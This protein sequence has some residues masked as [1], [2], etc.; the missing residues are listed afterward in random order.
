LA[1]VTALDDPTRFRRSRDAGA[2]VGLTPKRYQ[3]GEVDLAGRISRPG[4]GTGRSLLFKAANT[5]KAHSYK[6]CTLRN[7]GLSL[8]KPIGSHKAKGAVARKLATVLHCICLD[9]TEFEAAPAH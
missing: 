7:W 3:S 8:V 2:Y 4:D 6:D 5:V 9:G 1:F